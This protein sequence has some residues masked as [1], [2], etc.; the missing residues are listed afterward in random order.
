M[1][2]LTPVAALNISGQKHTHTRTRMVPVAEN[3]QETK[4]TTFL[5][6]PLQCMHN[7]LD[8]FIFETFNIKYAHDADA[9]TEYI[10]LNGE[11]TMFKTTVEMHIFSCY[12]DG[13]WPD[14]QP[15]F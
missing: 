12:C 11:G 15:P 7:L 2:H 8:V 5:Y 13:D 1:S 10:I 14:T 3:I 6:T 4:D 9:N